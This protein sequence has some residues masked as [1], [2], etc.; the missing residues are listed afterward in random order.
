MFFQRQWAEHRCLSGRLLGGSSAVCGAIGNGGRI[1]GTH[2]VPRSVLLLAMTPEEGE[3]E[4][5]Q[6]P[7]HDEGPARTS[8]ISKAGE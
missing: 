1:G 8:A 3:P 7:D 5:Q 4:G 2:L 6:E